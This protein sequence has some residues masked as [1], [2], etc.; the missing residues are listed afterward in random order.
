MQTRNWLLVL[1]ALNTSAL[2]AAGQK[3][4]YIDCSTGDKHHSTP[5]FEHPCIPEPVGH[6]S[7]QERV[8][9]VEREGPWLKITVGSAERYIGVASVSQKKDRFVALDLP[10]P[11]GQYAL[12]CS[13]FRPKTGKS[14]ARPIYQKNPEYTEE[15][16]RAGISGTVMLALTIDINGV[17]HDIRV[18]QPL[19]HGLD[20]KAVGAV[21]Q[22]KWEPALED[23]KPIESKI[24]IGVEFRTD[25]PK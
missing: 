21:Q 3:V 11:S 18:L 5:I 19:G 17:A 9:V 14:M 22:W 2:G 16:R 6:L 10:V 1:V 24:A 15:A 7:C 8:E 4:G 13:A 12:D 20:E 23:G 25:K